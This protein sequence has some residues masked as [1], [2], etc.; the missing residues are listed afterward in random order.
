MIVNFGAGKNSIGMV[1]KDDTAKQPRSLNRRRFLKSMFGLG[2]A[3]EAT[4]SEPEAAIASPT[5]SS[6]GSKVAAPTGALF[7][8]ADLLNG[9]VGFPSGLQVPHSRAGSVMKLVTAACLLEEGVF[10]P[11]DT[12]ECTG[13]VTI[14]GETYGCGKGHGILTIDQ[15]IA[16]SCNVFFAKVSRQIGPMAI[17][18]YARKFGMDSPAAGFKCGAFPTKPKS[19]TAR[20]AL[21]LSEDMQPSALQMLRLAAI[22]GTEGKVP[23]MKNAG[24]FDVNDL[25][26]KPFTVELR[27]ATFRRIRK[28]MI[29]A[30]EQGTAMKLD[31]E[32]KL[33]IAAKTG[34]VPHGKKFESWVIGYFPFDKPV[35]AF[36]L[37]APSGTSRDSAVPQAHAKLMSVYW[38]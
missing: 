15:A 32:R 6:K 23:A 28:G 14:A 2:G 34:T 20:Y 38:P 7:F 19:S 35:H 8:W 31:P 4:Q 36:C 18:D 11:N 9:N 29:L 5:S 22:F 26:I 10:N 3:L 17:I 24:M 13:S 33:K 21:G 12:E 27:E 1:G 16:L 30:C 25:S 37:F